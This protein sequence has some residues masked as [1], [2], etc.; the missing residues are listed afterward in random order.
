M[1]GTKRWLKDYIPIID[2]K[3]LQPVPIHHQW[4]EDFV[5]FC[6]SL[7]SF[8]VVQFGEQS[9]WLSEKWFRYRNNIF[10][11]LELLPLIVLLHD[12]ALHKLNSIELS[13]QVRVGVQEDSFLFAFLWKAFFV[14]MMKGPGIILGE[15]PNFKMNITPTY[16]Y[17]NCSNEPQFIVLSTT[18][19]MNIL[20]ILLVGALVFCITSSLDQSL[21]CQVDD[22]G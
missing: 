4:A 18:T 2:H 16:L 21:G 19:T 15:Q 7:H 11:I 10:D 13:Y 5:S 22:V 9:H 20:V 17:T 8:L 12:W 14:E 3:R 1:V 6:A